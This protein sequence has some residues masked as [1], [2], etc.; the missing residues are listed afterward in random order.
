MCRL[1]T[2]TIARLLSCMTCTDTLLTVP[3]DTL[4]PYQ[5]T[6][7]VRTTGHSQSVRTYEQTLL[8]P[9]NKHCPHLR[10]NTVRTDEQPLSAQTMR[11]SRIEPAFTNSAV[12]LERFKLFRSFLFV[13]RRRLELDRASTNNARLDRRARSAIRHNSDANTR[14]R[15]NKLHRVINRK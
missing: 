5:R 6:L 14:V 9:T 13:L 4:C 2:N 1:L 10:T 11:G 15:L 12:L 3:T 8:V 7:S